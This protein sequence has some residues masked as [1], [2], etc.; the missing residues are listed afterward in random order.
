MFSLS[1]LQGRFDKNEIK[2][3]LFNIKNN[4]FKIDAVCT[5]FVELW[6]NIED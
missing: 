1:K 2:N 5:K 4:N 3:I 6:N